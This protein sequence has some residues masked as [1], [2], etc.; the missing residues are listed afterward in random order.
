MSAIP[1]FDV[2]VALLG[3]NPNIHEPSGLL[4]IGYNTRGGSWTGRNGKHL[5]LRSQ[6]FWNVKSQHQLDRV[7]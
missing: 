3:L 5:A 2:S 4:H 7:S 6:L 1:G